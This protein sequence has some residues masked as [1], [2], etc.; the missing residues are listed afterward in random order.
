MNDEV[1]I[2]W[3]GHSCFRME[4]AGWSL[5]IDAFA[6]GSVEGLGNVRETANALYATHSHHDH[7]APETVTLV[8]A[9]APEGFAV[10]T[11]ETPHDHHGGTKRGMNLIHLFTFGGLKVAHMGDTGSV[12]APEILEKLQGVDLMLIPVGGFFTVGPE[13]ALRIVEK[14]GPKAVVPMHFRTEKFGFGVLADPKAFAA[15]FPAA[16]VREE[17]ALTLTAD[18]PRGLVVL[19]P[20]L[21]K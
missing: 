16:D 8:D 1:K 15:G 13:E 4:Y 20:A 7:C 17:S 12:P 19:T 21:L 6:D 14:T 5:I 9:P 10:E 18:G 3:L 11:L 2:K